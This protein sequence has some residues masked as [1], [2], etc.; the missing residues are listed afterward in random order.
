MT[1]GIRRTRS[2]PQVDLRAADLFGAALDQRRGFVMCANSQ[3]GDCLW[4]AVRTI[5]GSSRCRQE[6]SKL[7]QERGT[8]CWNRLDYKLGE[9][10]WC[11]TAQDKLAASIT[12]SETVITRRTRE[13]GF[14]ALGVWITFDGHV[15]KEM[16]EREVSTWRRFDVLRQLL[17][18]NKVAL[19]YR[20]RL[21]T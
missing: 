18:D 14:E 7:W 19:K 11:S 10:V 4:E 3:N 5:V 13:E 20:L 17:C 21:L 6:S 8:S 12:L 16:A 1:L 15:T 2:V 9:A